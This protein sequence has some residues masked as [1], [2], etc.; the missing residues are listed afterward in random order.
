MWPVY[1]S[2][3]R[4]VNGCGRGVTDFQLPTAA[5]SKHAAIDAYWIEGDHIEYR[6]D[7]DF[8]AVD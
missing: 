7:T 2:L 8:I 1:V 3:S 4:W 6:D 5:T